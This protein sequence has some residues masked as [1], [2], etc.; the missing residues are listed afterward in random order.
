MDRIAPNETMDRLLVYRNLLCAEDHID[1]I[2]DSATSS[3]E[4]QDLKNY[5]LAIEGV[6]SS[7][8]FIEEEPRYHCLTKHLAVAYE[9]A[10]EVAKAT[11]SE[12][13]RETAN[14]LRSYLKWS[15]EHLIGA[16]IENC[17]RCKEKHEQRV[18]NK[19]D[20]DGGESGEPSGDVARIY[21]DGDMD[22][23][24]GEEAIY[25]SEVQE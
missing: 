23:E 19:Q 9:A 3:T 14:L 25:F 15:L 4:L 1:E 22:A 17:G 24:R 5:K 21:E 8:G 16:P 2:M 7:L 11:H 6:R 12:S 18:E 10:R 20:A 13:D